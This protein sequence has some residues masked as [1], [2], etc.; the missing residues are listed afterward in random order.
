MSEPLDHIRVRNQRQKYLDDLEGSTD[1]QEVRLRLAAMAHALQMTLSLGVRTH[2]VESHSSL[3]VLMR[4][5]AHEIEGDPQKR[6]YVR[7]KA[8]VGYEMLM[9]EMH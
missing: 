1:P 7:E 4:A 3:E 5:V 9:G 8:R 2:G 6:G